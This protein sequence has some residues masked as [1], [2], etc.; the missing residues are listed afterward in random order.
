MMFKTI[1]SSLSFEVVGNV[2]APW[3][4]GCYSE[5]A[6]SRSP[7]MEISIRLATTADIET[8]IDL[9]TESLSNLPAQFRKYDRHQIQSLIAEQ[10]NS[11]A[12]VFFI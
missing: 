11:R 8:I 7:A 9:Q 12:D 5:E 4:G 1:E 10:A 3:C 2:I 6:K